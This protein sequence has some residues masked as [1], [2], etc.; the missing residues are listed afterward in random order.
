MAHPGRVRGPCP[1]LQYG[2]R[3]RARPPAKGGR[4]QAS[5]GPGRSPQET[6]R[7]FR[8]PTPPQTASP[9]DSTPSKQTPPSSSSPSGSTKSRTRLLS[10]LQT[11]T[12]R[13]KP[14]Q[15]RAE[16]VPIPDGQLSFEESTGQEIWNAN[17]TTIAYAS[18][19]DT[20]NFV[21][22]SGD[23]G[24]I[25][26]SFDHPT[27]TILPG[28]VLNQVSRVFAKLTHDDYSRGRFV[29]MLQNDGNL[30]LN[31]VASSYCIQVPGILVYWGSLFLG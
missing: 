19:L 3:A 9:S 23:T 1:S 20:G 18:M 27:D 25:W 2:D 22:F 6:A 30:V 17:V 5:P 29:L 26:Q 21:L 16:A 4:A 31:P 13:H 12:P 7:A 24:S 15:G 11:D 8:T 28:Q 14:V 10:G